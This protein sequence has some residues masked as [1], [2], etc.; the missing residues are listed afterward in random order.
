MISELTK[1][2]TNPVIPSMHLFLLIV[3][4]NEHGSFQLKNGN[5]KWSKLE[6]INWFYLNILI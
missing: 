5:W 1:T 2:S 6:Y 3:Q 4:Q